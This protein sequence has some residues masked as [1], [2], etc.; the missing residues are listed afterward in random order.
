MKGLYLFNCLLVLACCSVGFSALGHQLST[1]YLTLEAS[2]EANQWDGQLQLRFYDLENALGLDGDLDGQLR[3]NEVLQ[4]QSNIND[5]VSSHLTIQTD[6]Q[7]CGMNLSNDLKVDDHFDEGYLVIDFTASCSENIAAKPLGLTYSGLFEQDPNHKVVVNILGFG[8]EETSALSAVLDKTNQNMQFD[9]A[10][11][12]VAQTFVTYLYQGIVHIFIGIDHIL[13]LLVLM[14]TCVL[15]REHGKWYAQHKFTRVFKT[16][17]WIVTAFTAAH[18]ITLT[19][20]ALGWISPDSRWVEA[21]IALSV[22]LTA[23]NNIWPVVI[24]L[25][26]I[27]FAFGLLHGMGFAS[28]LTELGLSTQH[29][30]VSILAFNVGVEVGQLAILAL[31]L[32]ALFFLR[33]QPLYQGLL[34]KGGSV[35][36]GAIALVWTIERL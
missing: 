14:M 30:V 11:S 36:I 4:R 31:I 5:Y 23:L 17:A 10:K 35:F 18:S 25:G 2:P 15:Y 3:W 33:H 13:F 28:V 20:T 26:W 27:T 22:L 21:G 24:R 1:A 6:Q 34:L 29:Q 9:P 7:R 12:Y 8:Q 19:S 16:A 32:P